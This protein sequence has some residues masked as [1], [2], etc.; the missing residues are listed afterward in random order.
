[1]HLFQ[2]GNRRKKVNANIVGLDDPELVEV[3][4]EQL[5]NQLIE[6]IEVLDSLISEPNMDNVK[7]GR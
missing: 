3:I 6:D 4:G 1:M 5:Y 2:R 7:V